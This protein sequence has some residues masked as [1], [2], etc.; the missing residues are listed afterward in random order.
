MIEPASLAEPVCICGGPSDA[1]DARIAS[2]RDSTSAESAIIH[3]RRGRDRGSAMGMLVLLIAAFVLVVIAEVKQGSKPPPAI[4]APPLG[5]A[6]WL[7]L[8]AA[9]VIIAALLVW[10]LV[11]TYR[12]DP[13]AFRAAVSRPINSVLQRYYWVMF[14]GVALYLVVL[15]CGVKHRQAALL[16]CLSLPGALTMPVTLAAG[17]LVGLP[18]TDFAEALLEFMIHP[19]TWI[20]PLIVLGQSWQLLQPATKLTPAGYARIFLIA[21]LYICTI[22]ESV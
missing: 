8:A 1:S 11:A 9:G 7:R 5:R 20:L 15:L 22:F 18:E 12:A 13:E 16:F 2:W 19:A 4:D 14:S 17:L 21:V 6:V 3:Q 10:G